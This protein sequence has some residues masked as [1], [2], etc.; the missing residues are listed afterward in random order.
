MF[1]RPPKFVATPDAPFENDKLGRE[2]SICN[3]TTLMRGTDT[4]MVMTVSAPWG[5]G[6]SSFVQMWKA[7]LESEKG[8]KH[9]CIMFDAWKHDFHKEP[10]LAAMGEIGAFIKTHEAAYPEAR[11]FFEKCL[12]HAPKLLKAV[13]GVASLLSFVHPAVGI[14]GKG[15]ETAEKAI[16]NV[17]NY[18][19]EEYSLQKDSVEEFKQELA[20]FIQLITNDGETGPLYFFVDELDRCDPEYAIRLLESIKHFF[21]V[22][23]IVFVLSVDRKKLGSMVRVRYGEGFD[24][25]GYLKRFVDVDYEIPEPHRKKL[26]DYLCDDVHLLAN[27]P[28]GKNNR[29]TLLKEMALSLADDFKMRARDIEKIFCKISPLLTK[30]FSLSDSNAFMF[31]PQI[32]AG[33]QVVNWHNGKFG[34]CVDSYVSVDEVDNFFQ[35][36]IVLAFLKEVSRKHYDN[37]DDAY[38]VSTSPSEFSKSSPKSDYIELIKILRSASAS[39]FGIND[40]LKKM[41]NGFPDTLQGKA[42]LIGFLVGGDPDFWPNKEKE[43]RS[44]L[45]NLDNITFL[46]AED[47]SEDTSAA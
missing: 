1:R 18:V 45:D 17:N 37:I 16:K 10:L 32:K 13:G 3:L 4:P 8:G 26:I 44:Q 38:E 24:A 15:A 6:K 21:D 39:Q 25:D 28:I 43:I 11:S 42:L 27:Y 22:D 7:Y 36:L 47:G 31:D 19:F 5:S 23:G 40:D 2:C 34:Y 12:K 14:V 30:N 29:L 46:S 41:L 20:N 33:F 9:P 35:P